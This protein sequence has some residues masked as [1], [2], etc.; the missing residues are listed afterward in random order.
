MCFNWKKDFA[1]KI[2]I[3]ET[4]LFLSFTQP[5]Y[6][7]SLPASSFRSLIFP[8]ILT[9]NHHVQNHY[10]FHI[11]YCNNLPND[12]FCYLTVCSQQSSWN[13]PLKK[14]ISKIRSLLCSWLLDRILTPHT[15]CHIWFLISSLCEVP[16]LLTISLISSFSISSCL[17]CSS[18]LWGIF[19]ASTNLLIMLLLQGFAF[20]V[21]S[22]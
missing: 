7:T 12:P 16:S 14:K 21:H 8:T 3:L 15:T 17:L 19:A 18:W 20:P 5:I 1:T 9:A 10:H 2:M 4:P 13:N 6:D 11:C 22:D